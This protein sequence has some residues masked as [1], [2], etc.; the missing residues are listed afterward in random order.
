MSRS[1]CISEISAVK[2]ISSRIS[3]FGRNWTPLKT[4]PI[5][6]DSDS[7]SALICREADGC[8]DRPGSGT[9]TSA[10]CG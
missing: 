4:S 8:G 10:M 6:D 5:R 9:L 3:E 1:P 2:P 7:L